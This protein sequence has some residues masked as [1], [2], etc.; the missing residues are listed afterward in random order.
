MKILILGA[1][2]R[3]G[4]YLL[5]EALNRGFEVNILVRDSKKVKV[6]SEKLNIFE[7]NSR[8]IEDLRKAINGCNSTLSALNISRNSD[9]P[10]ANLRTPKDFLG[11]TVQNI[12]D[13]NNTNPLEKLIVI[14]A[15]GVD[16]T[17]K[18]LPFWFRWLVDYSNIKYGYLGHEEQEKLLQNSDLNWTS[19]RP[20][21]LTNFEKNE[22]IQTSQNNFPKPNLTISRKSVAQFMLDILVNKLFENQAVTI[23]AK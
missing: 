12:I 8:I 3:T 9:F 23:F 16:D 15:W 20:V 6:K 4:K 1:T 13:L 5:K 2:G 14:S 10:W 19:V 17:K 18:N 21:G 22:E 11:K 7:G